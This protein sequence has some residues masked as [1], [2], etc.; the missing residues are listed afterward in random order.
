MNNRTFINGVQTFAFEDREKLLY[1]IKNKNKILVALNAEKI[2]KDDTR[3]KTI[4]NDN[5][6]YPDGFG[7]VIAL[8]QKGYNAIKIPGAELW[9]DIINKFQYDKSFYLVGSSQNVIDLTIQKL[10]AQ[11]PAINIVGYRNGFIDDLGKAELKKSLLDTKPDVVFVAQGSPRQEY[12]MD[13][14]MHVHPA[15]Y[16]GLGGSFDVYSRL[17]KRAPK[18]FLKY[19]LEWLWRLLKEPTRVG[20]QS[21]LIKFLFLYVTKKL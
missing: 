15:L 11:F 3:L 10:Q 20:R 8:R 21:T 5:I 1:Y 13:E 14:L 12:F 18:L 7:A 6:G 2:V 9:L 17:K 19:H 4:I 16:M